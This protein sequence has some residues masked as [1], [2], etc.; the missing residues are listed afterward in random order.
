MI[1]FS[2]LIL[3]LLGGIVLVLVGGGSSLSQ[4]PSH[5]VPSRGDR[6][7]RPREIL[8]ERLARGKIDRDEYE[9]I[10]TRLE[11]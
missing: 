3:L 9:A 6:R 1:A 10:R 7:T 5:G 8:D 11:N 2:L 4:R